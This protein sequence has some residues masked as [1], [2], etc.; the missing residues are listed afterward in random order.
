MTSHRQQRVFEPV[1][2]PL[3]SICH[4]F[5]RR[6]RG[7]V[8]S[9]QNNSSGVLLRGR[10]VLTAAHNVHSTMLSKVV[11]IEVSVGKAT[12]GGEHAVPAQDWRVASDYGW[13]DFERDFAVLRLPT[14]VAVTRPFVLRADS[15]PTDAP[16]T[17]RI[18]GYPGA[19]GGERN[20]KNL[21]VGAGPASVEAGSAF[22]DYG[23][24][25][26]TGNSGGPVWIED[27]DGVPSIV[28]VHVTES[29]GSR[30]RAR[31]ADAALVAQ[32]EQMI[33]AM[34]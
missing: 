6:R 4:L 24:D 13:R 19:G 34:A 12:A 27:A 16:V 22:V 28:G 2:P 20:G 31:R 8:T 33:A 3:D 23:V 17:V 21:F 30:G 9:S 5:V 32:V 14:E 18:A 11:S 15:V 7:L 1:P 10:Y 25:T 26:E 29:P